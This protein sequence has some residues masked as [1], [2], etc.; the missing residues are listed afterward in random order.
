MDAAFKM[1]VSLTCLAALFF[2]TQSYVRDYQARQEK[3]PLIV[4]SIV[5]LSDDNIVSIVPPPD[6]LIGRT[7]AT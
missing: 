7:P 4:L 2:M 5:P 6:P 3:T 1:I